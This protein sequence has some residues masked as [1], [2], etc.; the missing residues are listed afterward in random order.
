[1]KKRMNL[2]RRHFWIIVPCGL[3]LLLLLT[4]CTRAINRSAER[5]IR[6]A[7]PDLLGPA[8][9]YRV[10][11][12]NAPD[13]TLRGRLST[14]TV[15]GS[16]VELPNGLLL[17]SLHL[18][19]KNVE[20]DTDR[21]RVNRV[22]EARFTATVREATL[23]HFLAG[24]MPENETIRNTRLTLQEGSVTI[25]AERVVFGFGIPF[26]VS[27][28][29]R[30]ANARR[31]EFDPTRLVVVGI[32]FSGRAVQ[33]LLRRFEGG[34]DLSIL[35]F[36]VQVSEVQVRRGFLTLTGAADVEAILRQAQEKR[37]QPTARFPGRAGAGYTV[38][39]D[40]FG[41]R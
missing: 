36:P 17:D 18:E 25:S 33:F 24:E 10:H 15:D 37:R 23:A 20:V 5:R 3:A 32:P 12:A 21:R 35:A 6:E 4:G 19:L 31:V 28:P 34:V 22:G 38:L 40:G 26:R 41:R 9:Q 2:P 27:G 14:V 13:R 1:M 8:R 16:D 39:E 11:I 7:L 29:L 30:V